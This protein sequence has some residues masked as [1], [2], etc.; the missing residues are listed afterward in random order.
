M[1]ILAITCI[2]PLQSLLQYLIDVDVHNIQCRGLPIT[3]EITTIILDNFCG[4]LWIPELTQTLCIGQILE[5]GL[6]Q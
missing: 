5:E 1:F 4:L 3:S 2:S 6:M